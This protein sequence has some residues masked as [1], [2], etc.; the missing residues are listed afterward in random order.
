MK[1]KK[2]RSG[3]RQKSAREK[4]VLLEKQIADLERKLPEAEGRAAGSIEKQLRLCREELRIQKM[5]V[6]SKLS[7]VYHYVVDGSYGSS[8]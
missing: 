4:V 5:H 7:S 6:I 1:K 3:V 8:R 2:R